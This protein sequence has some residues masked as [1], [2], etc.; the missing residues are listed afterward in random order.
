[1]MNILNNILNKSIQIACIVFISF[2]AYCVTLYISEGECC[3]SGENI[4]VHSFGSMFLTTIN[5][6]YIFILLD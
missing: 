5:A 6:K 1:M 3:F 4:G 2:S